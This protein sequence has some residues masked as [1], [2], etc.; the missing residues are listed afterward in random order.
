MVDSTELHGTTA[1]LL[2]S[3][4]AEPRRSLCRYTTSWNQGVHV[5]L[6]NLMEPRVHCGTADPRRLLLTVQKFMEPKV[7]C[8]IVGPHGTV[9]TI[10][11]LCYYLIYSQKGKENKISEY[12]KEEL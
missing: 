1:P 12:K 4:A 2:H 11:T 5:T 7:H 8:D 9:K 10:M 3:R 6:L